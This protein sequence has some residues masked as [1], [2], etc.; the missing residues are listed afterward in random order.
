MIS[1]MILTCNIL[2]EITASLNLF[3]LSPALKFFFPY[4]VPKG[5]KPHLFCFIFIF[6]NF[7]NNNNNKIYMRE[8][9][10]S[11]YST[12]YIIPTQENQRKRNIIL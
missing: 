10:K 12:R 6:Y 7:I 11:S 5:L 4:G 1:F 2:F 3:C 9:E 8:N